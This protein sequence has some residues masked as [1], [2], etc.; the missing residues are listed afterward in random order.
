MNQKIDQNW[1]KKMAK[2]LAKNG[3]F[4][5]M[6]IRTAWLKRLGDSMQWGKVKSLKFWP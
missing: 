6:A 3:H 1:Y 5:H 2:L 4:E